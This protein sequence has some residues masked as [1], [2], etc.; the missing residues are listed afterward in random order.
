VAPPP[1]GPTL[2]E[3]LV[4]LRDQ[5]QRAT[6]TLGAYSSTAVV[7]REATGFQVFALF[8]G[9]LGVSPTDDRPSQ[10]GELLATA[11]DLDELIGA[12]LALW[13]A[14]YGTLLAPHERLRAGIR[15]ADRMRW[16][17]ELRRRVQTLSLADAGAI[18]DGT[19][20][21]DGG[22]A[23]AVAA[24]AAAFGETIAWERVELRGR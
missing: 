19:A 18:V 7:V 9:I 20:L 22:L 13:T 3:T 24:T 5:A 11:A 10:I 12:L 21:L 2:G 1:P 14:D 6:V 4:L 17:V 23:R 15:D 16:M 8:G